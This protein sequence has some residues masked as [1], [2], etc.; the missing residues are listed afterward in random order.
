MRIKTYPM[1]ENGTLLGQEAIKYIYK[2]IQTISCIISH[3]IILT[4]IIYTPKSDQLQILPYI[5][6]M[7]MPGSYARYH[8]NDYTFM[9]YMSR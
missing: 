7:S 6:K 3:S 5:R 9:K 8:D 4:F 1:D 2:H